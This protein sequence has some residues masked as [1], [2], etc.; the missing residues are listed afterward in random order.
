MASTSTPMP[1]SGAAISERRLS[2]PACGSRKSVA[3]AA[4]SARPWTVVTAAS[5][6]RPDSWVPATVTPSG[7]SGSVSRSAAPTNASPAASSPS[8]PRLTPRTNFR[9][10]TPLDCSNMP[11]LTTLVNW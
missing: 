5:S 6:E 11:D 3:A 8:R 1:A 7:T 9:A 10:V 2:G 4:V